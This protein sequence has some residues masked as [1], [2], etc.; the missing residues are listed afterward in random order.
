MRP[1]DLP[2][3]VVER[4]RS[5]FLEQVKNEGKPEHIAEKIVEGKL[6]KFFE[7][8]SL[9]KQP[10]VKDTDRKVQDLVT[11]MVATLG[12]N[13]Q[14][15]R[16]AR[17]ALGEGAGEVQAQD[18]IGFLPL[19]GQHNNRRLDALSEFIGKLTFGC[20]GT[21]RAVGDRTPDSRHLADD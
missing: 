13:I 8:N 11:E 18:D 12:E 3:A 9:L 14:V 5:I 2:E 7:E 17:F 20:Q 1:E 19:G 6:R 16:F 4:E 10:F 15:S 21:C